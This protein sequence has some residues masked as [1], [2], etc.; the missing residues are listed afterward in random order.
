MAS[1]IV[2]SIPAHNREWRSDGL[3]FSLVHE[4]FN[5]KLVSSD[6]HAAIEQL[7]GQEAVDLILQLNVANFSGPKDLE[8]IILET[9]MTRWP[10]KYPGTLVTD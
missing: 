3:D 4:V 8:Q 10:E 7:T 9:V 2:Q 6:G 1:A 5:F